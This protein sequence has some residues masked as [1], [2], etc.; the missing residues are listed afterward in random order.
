M[1]H[2]LPDH[3]SHC[4]REPQPLIERHRCAPAGFHLRVWQNTCST[5]TRLSAWDIR[6]LGTKQACSLS[7]KRVSSGHFQHHR[8]YINR[9]GRYHYDHGRRCRSTVSRL[10]FGVLAPPK[11]I[12]FSEELYKQAHSR[13]EIP[14][15]G[16][17]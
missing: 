9:G 14:A 1:L 7:L 10:F 2:N 4:L 17:R 16:Y 6:L 11:T 5:V 8:L 15:A 13:Q 3:C 12:S